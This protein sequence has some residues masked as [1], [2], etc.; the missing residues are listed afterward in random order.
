VPLINLILVILSSLTLAGVILVIIVL[1][2]LPKKC[3]N[4]GKKMKI[5]SINLICE[6]CG[7][8]VNITH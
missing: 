6:K 7:F 8:V 4:C 3:P 5:A 1:W 2:R